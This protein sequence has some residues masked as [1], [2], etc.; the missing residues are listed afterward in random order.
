MARRKVLRKM[1]RAYR[2]GYSQPGEE[3]LVF[4]GRQR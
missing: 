3:T 2:A 4:A 1:N